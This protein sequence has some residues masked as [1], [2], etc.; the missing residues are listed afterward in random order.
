[1]ELPTARAAALGK[2]VD[3]LSGLAGCLLAS[4]VVCSLPFE[5]RLSLF[6][7]AAAALTE[8]SVV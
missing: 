5:L 7:G 2:G 3:D 8:R 1:M 4:R 6:H